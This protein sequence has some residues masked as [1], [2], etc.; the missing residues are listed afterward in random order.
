MYIECVKTKVSDLINSESKIKEE[1]MTLKKN[2]SSSIDHIIFLFLLFLFINYYN[3]P[4]T[5]ASATPTLFILLYNICYFIST[6]LL[7]KAY[8][9]LNNSVYTRVYVQYFVLLGS[10][11]K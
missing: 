5:R 3:F 7:F 11:A 2:E 6:G 1:G 9:Y 8:E 4:A 10:K